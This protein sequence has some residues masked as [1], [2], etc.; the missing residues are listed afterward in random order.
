M[1]EAKT[2]RRLAGL[3]SST[4]HINKGYLLGLL[5][6]I[7]IGTIQFGYS[8]GSWNAANEPYAILNDWDHDALLRNNAIIQTATSIGSALGALGAGQ[9]AH[10]G[11]WKCMMICNLFVILGCLLTFLP[12]FS[13]V[14][15]GRVLYGMAAGGFSVF[16]S[17]YISETAPKEIRGS[18]GG[19]T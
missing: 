16:C 8:I 14:I 17:K 5:L 3:T 19:L 10:F 2:A 12:Q 11:R 1:I 6:T 4:G 7:V 18:C 15:F 9:I 13:V